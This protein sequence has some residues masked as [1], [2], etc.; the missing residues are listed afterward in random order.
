VIVALDTNRYI[1]FA[2]GVPEVVQRLEQ[3]EVIAVPLIVLA[4]LRAGFYR[5]SKPAEN[6]RS[7]LLF[8]N[9]KRVKVICPDEDTSH[10]YGRVMGQL[11]AAG[12]PI[13]INDIWIAAL[14]LQHRMVLYTRDTD[15][16]RI[17]NLALLT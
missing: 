6:E 14:V 5:S 7:L 16:Q 12:Q 17:P 9:R 1:D 10:H 13:P 11:R 8:L 4:E 3:A 2:R 15:F